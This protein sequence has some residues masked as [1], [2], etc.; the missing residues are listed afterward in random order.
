MA[1]AAL[2]HP[3][4]PRPAPGPA[5][6]F[7]HSRSPTSRILTSFFMAPLPGPD[8]GR[9]TSGSAGEAEP[10]R[11]G[12]PSRREPPPPLPRTASSPPRS[13][14]RTAAREGQTWGAAACAPACGCAGRSRP[15]AALRRFAR[16][17]LSE[18]SAGLTG[19][20]PALRGSAAPGCPGTMTRF[21]AVKEPRCR[22]HV[23]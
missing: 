15:R 6:P 16:P 1:T 18:P 17:P 11:P 4:G 8:A 23:L 22:F 13:G 19:P 14:R 7:P 2:P 21:S 20:C 12:I 3:S 9:L 5:R 10:L